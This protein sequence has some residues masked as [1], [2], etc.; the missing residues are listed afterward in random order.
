MNATDTPQSMRKR[1]AHEYYTCCQSHFS[2]AYEEER[3][4]GKLCVLLR[5][6]RLQDARR[7]V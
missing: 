6:K 1:S 5:M 2:A 3:V 4:K 7:N